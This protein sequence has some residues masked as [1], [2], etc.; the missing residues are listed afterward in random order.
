MADNPLI[1]ISVRGLVEFILRSGD[2]DNT[3]AGPSGVDVMLAGGR[4]HRKLQSERGIGYEAEVP[5]SILIPGD[6]YSLVIEG[7]A[8]GV[9]T[10]SGESPDIII[11][12]IKGTY[13]KIE[14]MKEPVPVHLAQAKCYAYIY[15]TT[16]PEAADSNLIGVR[17]T[18]ANLDDE[19]VR[20]FDFCFGREELKAWFE[21]LV[22]QYTKWADL[23][24]EWKIKRTASIKECV[25]P[26]DYRAGQKKLAVSV[27][28]TIVER[29]KLYLEAP[30][31]C[32]KTMS[33]LFPS[34][35][36]LGEGKADRIFY[37]TA[38]TITRTAPEE[39]YEILR[40]RGL[41]FKT[42]TLTAKEKICF[43]EKCD[44]NPIG[45]E[46]AK[47]HYDRIND[48]LFALVSE[49]TTYTRE[50]ILEYAA[51]YK[52]C[53][54]ELSL[55][56]SL[57]ADGIICDYNY[58][59]DPH[60]R[61]KRFFESGSSENFIFLVDEAHNLPSRAREM[62]SATVSEKDLKSLK[63]AIKASN[64]G[65]TSSAFLKKEYD[66]KISSRI[67]SVL[68]RLKGI[69][70]E[71][72]DD[73]V[74]AG[75]DEDWYKFETGIEDLVRSMERLH[76]AISDYMEEREKPGKIQSALKDQILDIF[77]DITDFL[78]VFE[79]LG[80]DYVIY[81][82]YSKEEGFKVMLFCTDP[83][84]KVRE[85]LGFG[86]S[87]VLFSATMLP[88]RYYKGLLGGTDEDYEVYAESVFDPSR[89]GI[90]IAN[91]VTT[92]FKDRSEDEFFRTADHI[93][94]AVRPKRGNYMVFFPSYAYMY[95]V[96][97]IYTGIFM[98]PGDEIVLQQEGMT[99]ADKEDFLARFSEAEGSMALPGPTGESG[100]G[101]RQAS[102]ADSVAMASSGGSLIGFCVMGGIFSEGI[103][104]KGDSL[105]G[106]ICVG[107]GIPG[108]DLEHDILRDYF[109][110]EDRL[111][112]EYA[113]MYPGM[114]KVLQ[115]AGRVI[116][117]EMDKGIVVLLD[118][119][120][121]TAGYK[122][123]FPREWTN[124]CVTDLDHIR[125]DVTRFW[126]ENE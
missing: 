92:R 71:Y 79:D 50:K 98:M 96:Y 76:S 88:I 107:P 99:E 21:D 36:A 82:T 6:R 106:V 63:N 43:L 83:G 78:T 81:D 26:F 42:V 23:E 45:C 101:E 72:G 84:R 34:V 59:F 69:R 110:G 87:S 17:M 49:G 37:L 90:F 113:Y 19:T 126:E 120:F 33:V 68:N 118:K 73:T 15:L 8:D 22:I 38:K 13:R 18:Y 54:F 89:R 61:L 114:N 103:D 10:K 64:G 55:D 27:Y 119:R 65:N 105:I 57:F 75:F 86:V 112:Y 52:V 24:Y 77:F 39:A 108:V 94:R 62:Y 56:A 102:D 123:L 28:Q 40:N 91:D 32:G 5:L 115:A 122:R 48:A 53:P 125:D 44:C 97:D 121:L 74:I 9:Y 95:K 47:G 117:T 29:K 41:A 12:E 4:M 66:K 14:K 85:S 93:S 124:I 104:L 60:A 1:S 3:E 58:L 109:D 51:K 35:K 16:K 100:V 25:F 2:I 20:N 116:R 7:R 111:G 11:E 31:G 46:Y 70:E 80:D 67:G 30:T